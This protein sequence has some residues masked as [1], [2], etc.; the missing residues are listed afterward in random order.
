MAW[1]RPGAAR[2]AGAIDPDISSGQGESANHKKVDDGPNKEPV[3]PSDYRGTLP[4]DAVARKILE[5]AKFAVVAPSANRKG[6]TAATQASEVLAEL[7]GEVDL[8]L[9]GGTCR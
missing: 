1:D 7:D 8:L 2:L 5:E 3:L 4:K 6:Q 9:D